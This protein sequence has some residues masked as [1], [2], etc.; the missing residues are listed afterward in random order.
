[1]FQEVRVELERL[2]LLNNPAEDDFV[3]QCVQGKSKSFLYSHF[4]SISCK[5]GLG[6]IAQ[7]FLNMRRP[8]SNEVRIKYGPEKESE[9]LGHSERVM[10]THYLDLTMDD[11][12]DIVGK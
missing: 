12:T 8:R 2:R 3:I 6:A 5:A 10:R 11:F 7:P 4:Q 9:R 1:L